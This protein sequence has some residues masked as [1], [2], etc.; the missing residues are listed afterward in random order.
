[1]SALLY[2]FTC[3]DEAKAQTLLL[4]AAIEEGWPDA[5]D[6]LGNAYAGAF[7]GFARNPGK[8]LPLFEHAATLGVQAAM[9]KTATSYL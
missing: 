2:H 3:R 9:F 6:L 8:A 4:H 1:M 7:F 5:T